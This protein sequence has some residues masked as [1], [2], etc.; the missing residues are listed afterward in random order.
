M[1]VETGHSV[2]S[3]LVE[4][5]A[6][7]AG[8]VEDKLQTVFLNFSPVDDLDATIVAPNDI[9]A[10]S[11]AMPGLVGAT[12]R[13]GGH[14]AA[15][16]RDINL[17]NKTEPTTTTTG[18]VTIKLF[19]MACRDLGP[20]LAGQGIILRCNRLSALVK[21]MDEQP[22]AVENVTLDGEQLTCPNLLQ[23]LAAMPSQTKVELTLLQA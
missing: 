1:V 11:A 16:R 5:L 21:D 3:T 13:R 6:M 22:E 23:K 14:L 9:I 18:L 7:D 2:R 12:L 17:Q 8:Y 10:L 20:S 19:N 15:M 4:Q